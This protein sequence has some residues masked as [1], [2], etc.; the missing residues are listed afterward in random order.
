MGV[1][2]TFFDQVPH[3]L[4]GDDDL[5][6]V[7]AGEVVEHFADHVRTDDENHGR[8]RRIEVEKSGSVTERKCSAGSA[9]RRSTRQALPAALR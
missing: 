6:L 3:A 7:G 1:N 9:L 5:L 8:K 2:R 4:P